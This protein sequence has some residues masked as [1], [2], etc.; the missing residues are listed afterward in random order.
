M[1]RRLNYIEQ[2]AERYGLDADKLD[3][4]RT[5]A[6]R[7]SPLGETLELC[8]VRGAAALLNFFWRDPGA[9]CG[10]RS[11]C[12]DQL[13]MHSCTSPH[14]PHATSPPLLSIQMKL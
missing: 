12:S 5:S 1:Q 11:C 4:A 7:A 14:V 8:A 10:D 13:C 9:V 6:A 2:H 3:S